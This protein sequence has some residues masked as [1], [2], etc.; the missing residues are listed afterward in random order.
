MAPQNRGSRIQNNKPN[1]I[2][3]HPKPSFLY[4]FVVIVVTRLF[5]KLKVVLL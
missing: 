5:V 1:P 4:C 2:L 3:E